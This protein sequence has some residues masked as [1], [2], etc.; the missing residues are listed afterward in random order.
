MCP[1]RTGLTSRLRRRSC[2]SLL[3]LEPGASGRAQQSAQAP[4]APD[5][6]SSRIRVTPASHVSSAGALSLKTTNHSA[7]IVRKSLALFLLG[8]R[9][10]P[11][12][13][14]QAD[15][16]E[17]LR[18][19]AQQL[20]SRRIHLFTQQPDVVNIRSSFSPAL[21]ADKPT[22]SLFF[23]KLFSL[24]GVGLGR[25]RE[26]SGVRRPRTLPLAATLL[27]RPWRAAG[28]PRAEG[29]EPVTRTLSNTHPQFDSDGPSCA[30]S[31][32][33]LV[34]RK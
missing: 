14:H 32:S 11:G 16:A 23:A 19:V 3:S 5:V 29:A 31:G 26:K 17:C 30:I 21:P 13:V 12:G 28:M 8:L 10:G 18:E 33:C 6:W 15:V 1:I 27:P 2:R 25:Q 22:P 4:Q 9:D 7:P 34:P 24:W 20:T